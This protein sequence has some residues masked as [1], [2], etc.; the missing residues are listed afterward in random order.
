MSREPGMPRFTMQGVVGA[1][2]VGNKLVS[3]KVAP[4]C[5]T[6]PRGIRELGDYCFSGQDRLIEVKLIN[7]VSVIGRAC[8]ANCPNLVRIV[9]NNRLRV[10]EKELRS[11]NQAVIVY[12]E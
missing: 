4:A 8:F 1:K 6:I 2:V 11:G 9:C 7:D 5:V 10:Y 3:C 12:R